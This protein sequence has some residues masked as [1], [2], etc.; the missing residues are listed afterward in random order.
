MFTVPHLKKKAEI[1][2]FCF[3]DSDSSRIY[4]SGHHVKPLISGFTASLD[5]WESIVL[6]SVLSF[7]LTPLHALEFVIGLCDQYG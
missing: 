1:F 6:S 5:S 7:H 3:T 4:E 2:V